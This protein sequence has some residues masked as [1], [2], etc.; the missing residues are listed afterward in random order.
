MVLGELLIQK[1]EVLILVEAKRWLCSWW[2]LVNSDIKWASYIVN[3]TEE[4]D[5][6]KLT[7]QLRLRQLC[8]LHLIFL[9][10]TCLS[11]HLFTPWTVSLPSPSFQPLLPWHFVCIM[12]FLG[13]DYN[14][15]T[16][17]PPS[18]AWVWI[19]VACFDPLVDAYL[20]WGSPCSG[21][22]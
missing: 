2:M 15:L 6:S 10:K 20:F 14:W 13:N 9:L 5:L 21:L 18:K 19:I 3:E 12:I 1:W 11:L 4:R 22:C 7:R 8:C 17:W 16:P